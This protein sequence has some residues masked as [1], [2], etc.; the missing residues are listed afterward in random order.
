LIL[1]DEKYES[2][3]QKKYLFRCITNAKR[4]RFQKSLLN[5]LLFLLYVLKR[6]RGERERRIVTAQ[7]TLNVFFKKKTNFHHGKK[8]STH[9]STSKSTVLIYEHTL[10][11]ID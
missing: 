8:G 2:F 10:V 4:L 5:A 7:I 3:F 1:L 9:L 6:E 11:Q